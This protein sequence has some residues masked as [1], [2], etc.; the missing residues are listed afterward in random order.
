MNKLENLIGTYMES[1]KGDMY[2]VVNVVVKDNK[3][4]I[5]LEV[6]VYE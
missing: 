6:V 3:S 2:K 1:Y 5:K 4:I